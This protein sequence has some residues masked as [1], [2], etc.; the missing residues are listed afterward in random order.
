VLP[1][2][3][4]KPGAHAE[5][6]S[7]APDF[8]HLDGESA[9]TSAGDGNVLPRSAAASKRVAELDRAIANPTRMLGETDD[10]RAAASLV[11]ER[12]SIRAEL[13]SL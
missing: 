3:N 6:G 1:R 2:R 9:R 7:V 4:L 11:S 8:A 12:A 5:E 10:A 13:A